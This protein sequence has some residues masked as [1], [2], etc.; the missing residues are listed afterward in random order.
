MT[1]YERTGWRDRALSERHRLYGRNCPMADIDFLAVEY[2]K[3]EASALIE[4]KHMMARN[5]DQSHPTYAA[6]SKLASN[7]NIPFYIVRYNPGSWAYKLTPAN[8]QA[9]ELTFD[10][11]CLSEREYV[12]FLYHLRGREADSAILK[13]LNN[14][15]P[16]GGR[17]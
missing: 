12:E 5:V 4:Y 17:L 7:S 10:E 8:K 14:T 16:Q 1:T 6:M 9:S 15:R 3:K 2:D 11:I 13:K